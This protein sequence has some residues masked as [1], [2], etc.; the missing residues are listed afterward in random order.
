MPHIASA[1][2]DP[3][4]EVILAGTLTVGGNVTTSI[5]EIVSYAQQF[6][7]RPNIVTFDVSMTGF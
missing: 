7:P 6:M 2:F 1:S 4:P 5:P 3:F